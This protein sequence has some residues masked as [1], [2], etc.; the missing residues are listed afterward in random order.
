MNIKPCGDRVLVRL[1][2]EHP[3]MD[4]IIAA[5]TSVKEFHTPI[6]CGVVLGIGGKCTLPI[7]PGDIVCVWTNHGMELPDTDAKLYFSQHVVLKKEAN[8]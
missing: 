7:K 5:P 8:A 3:D 4:T 1:V 6:E 2:E